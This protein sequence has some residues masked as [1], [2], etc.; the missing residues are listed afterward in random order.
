MTGLRSWEGIMNWKAA[1]VPALAVFAWATCASA[2]P[3]VDAAER[4]EELQAAGQTVEAL[5]ALAGA[6]DALWQAAPLSF[7]NVTLV[8]A[9]SGYGAYDAR[10]ERNFQPDEALK[11]YVEPVGYGF[12]AGDASVSLA[13]DLA[14][15]NTTGQV[16]TELKDAFTVESPGKK[17]EFS[18]TLSYAV[19]YLRPGDYVSV[20]TVR[21][22]HSGKS[23]SFEVPFSIAA[24]AGGEA[25]PEGTAAPPAQ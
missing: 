2:G 14:L 4:A 13:V 9:S 19:P 18:L 12:G 7:R 3:I 1:S 6:V 20:Y 25:A 22:R 5:D 11:V 21:D 16:L 23:G 8:D 17:H 24:P 10:S 15:Q